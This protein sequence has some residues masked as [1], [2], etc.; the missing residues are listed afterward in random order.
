MIEY[1]SSLNH[2]RFEYV[3]FRLEIYITIS[4][5]FPVH[6][7]GRL[8]GTNLQNTTGGAMSEEIGVPPSGF[9]SPRF[10]T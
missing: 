7:I 2:N 5:S 6:M 1:S 9:P 8:T 10:Q 4:E 3:N